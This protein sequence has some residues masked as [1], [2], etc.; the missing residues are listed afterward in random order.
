MIRRRD[1]RLELD[2]PLR[3]PLP[4]EDAEALVALLA[5]RLPRRL[6]AHPLFRHPNAAALLTGES[7]DHATDG[8]RIVQEEGETRLLVSASLPPCPALLAAGLEWIGGILV[9]PPGE[10]P[11]F[12]VPAG[13]SRHDLRL[14]AWDGQRLRPL[15]ALPPEGPGAPRCSLESF[16]V[17]A[18][19]P[20]MEEED[21]VLRAALRRVALAQLEGR[22][23]PVAQ[24]R[25]DGP[26]Q[27]G[28]GLF[29]VWMARALARLDGL[30]TAS[31]PLL[32]AC[33]V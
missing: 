8:S 5:G 4:L 19:L 10:V 9:L 3:H 17:A 18:G 7:L 15:A 6:P 1:A 13:E 12:I 21:G 22:C 2:A 16:L 24:A 27:A 30:S 23:L 11:G 20:G 26:F 28:Q 14:L 25:L 32:A 31:P 33:R 29:R